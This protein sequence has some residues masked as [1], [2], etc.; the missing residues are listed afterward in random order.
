MLNRVDPTS[1]SSLVIQ[2]PLAPFR[3]RVDQ[4]G[5]NERFS[6]SM[7]EIDFEELDGKV[8]DKRARTITMLQEVAVR[9][10]RVR[11]NRLCDVTSDGYVIGQRTHPSSVAG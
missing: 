10:E 8:E 11:G 7:I 4:R 3:D 9:L 2:G 6:R 5:A 1:R